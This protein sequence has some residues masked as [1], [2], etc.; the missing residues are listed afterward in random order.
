MLRYQRIHSNAVFAQN[1]G[2]A[3]LVEPHQP[4]ITSHIGTEYCCQ[5]ALD[6]VLPLHCHRAL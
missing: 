5:P 4:R 6:P 2:C 1:L 3:N